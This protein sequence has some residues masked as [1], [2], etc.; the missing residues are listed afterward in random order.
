VLD[1][2]T[3][4][5]LAQALGA[6]LETLDQPGGIVEVRGS[7]ARLRT[8]SERRAALMGADKPRRPDEGGLFGAGEALG[9]GPILA[10]RT[11]LDRLHQA[12]LL[13]G[14]GRGDALRRLLAEPRYGSDEGFMRLA[15][16][17]SALYSPS[18]QEKRWV[19]GVLATRPR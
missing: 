10:G 15:R 2:D 18:S 19:D 16:S 7:T 17:L 1:Y 12:M 5:K 6:H 13:F 9:G 8:V 4:R 11:T 14:D 3:A